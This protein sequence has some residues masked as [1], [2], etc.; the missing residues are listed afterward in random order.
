MRN[1][2]KTAL[3][4]IV[5]A[6][7]TGIWF[8]GSGIITTLLFQSY[9]DGISLLPA[10]TTFYLLR[11]IGGG[12]LFL[13]LR[14]FALMELGTGYIQR[15]TYGA[16]V[17]LGTVPVFLLL[18]SILMGYVAYQTGCKDYLEYGVGQR[19]DVAFYLSAAI[20]AIGNTQIILIS[21][22][23]FFDP[24]TFFIGGYLAE[25]FTGHWHV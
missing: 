14:R 1:W 11:I 5:A 16:K 6:I 12:I 9:K 20:T 4:S 2:R 22:F 23:L 17:W 24:I 3:A 10:Q 21:L 7:F 18:M 8:V 25:K 15:L 13:L 19:C